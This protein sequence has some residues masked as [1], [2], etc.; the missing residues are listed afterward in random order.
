M[1]VVHVR[2]VIILRLPC[3]QR[4]GRNKSAMT[5]GQDPSL[6]GIGPE[7]GPCP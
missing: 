6:G 7:F 3:R 4:V 2:A 5:M 1:T